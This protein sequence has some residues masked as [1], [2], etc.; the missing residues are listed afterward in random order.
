MTLGVDE[1][2]QIFADYFN[3]VTED[4]SKVLQRQEMRL[5]DISE[6]EIDDYKMYYCLIQV[7][8]LSL[9][10]FFTSEKIGKE[11]LS[12]DPIPGRYDPCIPVSEVGNAWTI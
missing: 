9:F 10:G 12:F 4:Q 6:S 5:S 7:R 1:M 11:V 3:L 8:K 2:A